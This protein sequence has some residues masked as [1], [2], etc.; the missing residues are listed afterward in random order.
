L[1]LSLIL[2]SAFRHTNL[3]VARYGHCTFTAQELV[4]G[5]ALLVLK[6]TGQDLF[7]R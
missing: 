4:G 3:P 1:Q 2:G 6:V 7:A 5:F